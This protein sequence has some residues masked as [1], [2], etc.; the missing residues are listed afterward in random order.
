MP[1]DLMVL[2]LYP[3]AHVHFRHFTRKGIYSSGLWRIEGLCGNFLN[4]SGILGG[5][6]YVCGHTYQP[7]NYSYQLYV[8]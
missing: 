3:K 6:K 5:R 4:G 2:W 7:R 8:V 1:E